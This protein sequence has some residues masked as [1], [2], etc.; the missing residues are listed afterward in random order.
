M[1]KSTTTTQT[2]T[3]GLSKKEMKFT[4]TTNITGAKVEIAEMKIVSA[5]YSDTVGKFPTRMIVVI[6][7]N[8]KKFYQ[9][10]YADKRD[11]G[12]F[13]QISSTK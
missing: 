9:K 6:E 4:P 5:T 13:E 2:T 10:F 3:T 11:Q 7:R 1:K 8:G 12:I